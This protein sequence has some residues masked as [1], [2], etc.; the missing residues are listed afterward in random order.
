MA[1]CGGNRWAARDEL[2]A[3]QRAQFASVTPTAP[4]E[5]P[6][7]ATIGLRHSGTTRLLVRGPMSG[8]AYSFGPNEAVEVDARDADAL[9]RTH[10]F[11]HV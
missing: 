8:H 1:C 11:Q 5:Q 4:T 6:A 7:G 3:R 2:T 9:L 10:L